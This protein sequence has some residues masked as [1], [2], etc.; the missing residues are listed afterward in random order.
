MLE[1]GQHFPFL[2]SK[3]RV[4]GGNG[5]W[6]M[7]TWGT[8]AIENWGTTRDLG[9]PVSKDKDMVRSARDA[10]ED[11]QMKLVISPEILSFSSRKIEEWDQREDLDPCYRVYRSTVNTGIGSDAEPM[12]AMTTNRG[13]RENPGSARDGRSRQTMGISV[14]TIPMVRSS[15]TSFGTGNSQSR[16]RF[17][18]GRVMNSEGLS[19]KAVTPTSLAWKDRTVRFDI[20]LTLSNSRCGNLAAFPV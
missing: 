15:T 19:L 6:R 1:H 4:E 16:E 12:G 8:S 9:F 18:T 10:A 17:L 13:F 14:D 3:E 20:K 7:R 2:S 5:H 11:R